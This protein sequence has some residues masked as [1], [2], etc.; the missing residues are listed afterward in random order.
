MRV[1]VFLLIMMFASI[2]YSQSEDNAKM[3]KG[4]GVNLTAKGGYYPMFFIRPSPA[5]EIQAIAG[6]SYH[7][8]NV[9]HFTETTVQGW[10]VGGGVALLSKSLWQESKVTHKNVI[11]GFRIGFKL[12][13]GQMQYDAYKQFE[14]ST[15]EPYIYRDSQQKLKTSY[16]E[17][18]LAYELKIKDRVTIDLI[19][20][21]LGDSGVY[22]TTGFT[23]PYSAI[24]GRTGV[25]LAAGIAINYLWR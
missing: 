6:Y 8:P 25:P 5:L 10:F 20:I 16:G 21:I 24:G 7:K 2:V 3:L 9:S 4:V 13:R 12:M 23:L 22:S 18:S 1:N 15:F 17:F 19:P 11:G 14:G